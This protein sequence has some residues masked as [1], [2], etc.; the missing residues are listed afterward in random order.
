VL[1]G[2]GTRP[3]ALETVQPEGKRAMSAL[4]WWRGARLANGTCFE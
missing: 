2:T 4:D 3:L 1:V